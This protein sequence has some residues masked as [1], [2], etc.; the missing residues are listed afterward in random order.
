MK[1]QLLA[2]AVVVIFY[3]TGNTYKLRKS[4][5]VQDGWQTI[6]RRKAP[7]SNAYAVKVQ[8]ELTS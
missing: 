1:S 5:A 4:R 8:D 2:T 6:S 7:V 3:A